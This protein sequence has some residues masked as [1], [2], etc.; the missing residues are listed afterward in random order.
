MA[1]VNLTDLIPNLTQ[2]DVSPDTEDFVV[3]IDP[4][5]NPRAGEAR[6]FNLKQIHDLFN[7][8]LKRSN[9]QTRLTNEEEKVRVLQEKV[10]ELEGWRPDIE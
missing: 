3:S 9:I 5:T 4:E 6:M 2:A 7:V 10:A 1:T 8:L